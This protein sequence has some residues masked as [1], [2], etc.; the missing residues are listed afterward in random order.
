MR[1]DVRSVTA[2]AALTVLA[3]AAPAAP[4]VTAEQFL[5]RQSAQ[6]GCELWRDT[7]ATR[8]SRACE[9]PVPASLGT[10]ARIAAATATTRASEPGFSWSAAAIAAGGAVALLAVASIAAMA[11]TGR[12]GICTAR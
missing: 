7:H 2:A 12:R 6:K 5:D 3:L 4:A 8:P 9:E 11:L 10:G 1:F